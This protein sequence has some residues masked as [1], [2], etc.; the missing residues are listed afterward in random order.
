MHDLISSYMSEVAD[1]H[2]T[3]SLGRRVNGSFGSS[4]QSGSLGPRVI[5][6]TQCATRFFYFKAPFCSLP[7]VCRVFVQNMFKMGMFKIL[8]VESS[9]EVGSKCRWTSQ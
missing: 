3:G 7:Y 2:G 1:R 4:F 9:L 5:I 6:M 8:D